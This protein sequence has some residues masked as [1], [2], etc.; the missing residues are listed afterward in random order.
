MSELNKSPLIIEAFFNPIAKIWEAA[1]VK[2]AD[3]YGDMPDVSLEVLTM[4]G[5]PDMQPSDAG[6]NPDFLTSSAEQ[7]RQ[8]KLWADLRKI[9][10]TD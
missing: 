8:R 6:N 7:E 3:G 2:S 9:M 5:D 1:P 10:G 4:L